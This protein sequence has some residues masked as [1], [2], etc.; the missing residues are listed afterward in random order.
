V[1]ALKKSVYLRIILYIAVVSMLVITLFPL[2]WMI[3]IS[4]N[5]SLFGEAGSIFINNINLDGYKK[6]L[7]NPNISRWLLNSIFV[8]V[9]TLIITI[10][11]STLAAYALSRFYNREV[12]LGGTLL[13]LSQMLPITM[14][15]IPLYVLFAKMH[16]IN[17]LF[18]LVLANI[19]FSLPFCSWMLKAFFDG[20]PRELEEAAQIDGCGLWKSF[21][22]IIIPLS[23]PGIG[24]VTIYT[25]MLSWG[26][27]IFARTLMTKPI[28]YTA[29]VAVVFFRDQYSIQ[30]NET[31]AAS[32]IFLLPI[33]IVFFF[34]EKYL[35]EGLTEGAIK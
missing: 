16:L 34:M 30:W 4:L 10:P 14:L 3:K 15:T 35:V 26:E 18:A 31:M 13:L 17:N 22:K 33:L 32:L 11:V 28:S 9:F 12:A 29:G 6:V 7:S 19:S 21:V 5:P 2:Y 23:K 20:L 1:F 27:F 8:T 24:A 25:I